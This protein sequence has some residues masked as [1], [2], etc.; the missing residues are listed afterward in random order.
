MGASLDW[1]GAVYDGRRKAITKMENLSIVVDLSF[2]G[3]KKEQ[4]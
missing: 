3:R 2:Q 1:R 4:G